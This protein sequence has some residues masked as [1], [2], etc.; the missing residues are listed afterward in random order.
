MHEPIDNAR[1]T[2]NGLTGTLTAGL[3][4][5]AIISGIAATVRPMG[6]QIKSL[7][8]RMEIVESRTVLRGNDLSQLRA[9]VVA[10]NAHASYQNSEINRLREAIERLRQQVETCP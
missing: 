8:N 10:V 7:D 9:Q 4:V 1:I 6:N 5:V 2:K 3:A